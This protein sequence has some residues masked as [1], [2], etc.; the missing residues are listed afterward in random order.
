MVRILT[1]NLWFDLKLRRARTAALVKIVQAIQPSIC[2]F[3]EVVPEVAIELKKELSDY[4]SSDPGTGETLGPYG[5][6]ILVS[7]SLSAKFH[8]C[9]LHTSMSRRLLIAEMP[10]LTVATVHLESLANHPTRELQLKECAIQ[11]A[12][13]PDAVLVGDFNFDSERNFAPPHEPLE[14]AALS[15]HLPDYVDLWPSLRPG[16][17]G[18]T[19]DSSVNTYIGKSELMRYDRIMIR[20]QNWKARSIEMVGHKPL[21]HLVELSEDEQEWLRRPPTPP[22]PKPRPRTD[23]FGFGDFVS[24]DLDE[25]KIEKIGGA[26]TPREKEP[27]LFLSDHFGLLAVL[28]KAVDYS[29]DS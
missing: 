17:R 21:E 27:G 10:D 1:L 18:L 23:P 5:V 20:L 16:E 19:F 8:F 15:K 14:N 2:C 22:R 13:Y 12:A 24:L 6:M 9:D 25:E 3:Q 7:P 29:S 4:R 28:E 26:E 11:L